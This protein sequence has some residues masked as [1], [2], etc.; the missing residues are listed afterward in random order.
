MNQEKSKVYASVKK[1]ISNRLDIAPEAIDLK[2]HMQDDLGA[3]SLDL[4]ELVL[5]LEDEYGIPIDEDQAEEL[6]T[7]GDVVDFIHT[8]QSDLRDV[9]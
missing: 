4:V 2:A 8:A 7:I 9:D 3:D 6:Q 5:H 1:I